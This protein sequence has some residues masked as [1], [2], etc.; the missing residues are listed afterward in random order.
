MVA[1]KAFCMG[2]DKPNIR[3]QTCESIV[4]WGPGERWEPI[5]TVTIGQREVA[6]SCHCLFNSMKTS[7]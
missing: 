2:I 5:T 4:S 3:Y 6:S 7:V 1:T